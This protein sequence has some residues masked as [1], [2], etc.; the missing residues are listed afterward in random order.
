[1]FSITVE[2]IATKKMRDQL[3]QLCDGAIVIF[4]GVVRNH[5]QGKSVTHLEYDAYVDLAE[6][7]GR[8]ILEEADAR[9]SVS[10]VIASHRIG[11]LNLGETAVWIGVAAPHREAAFEACR[12]V[13]DQIK[14][15][16]PIWKKEHYIDHVSAWLHPTI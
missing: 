5:H 9:F 15:R 6:R 8:R 14:L 12:W 11:S 7:E 16:V 13:I 10:R 4:E 1:M 3:E 2:S